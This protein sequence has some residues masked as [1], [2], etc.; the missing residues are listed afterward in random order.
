M[1]SVGLEKYILYMYP[2]SITINILLNYY[3]FNSMGMIGLAYSTLVVQF[4]ILL[5]LM[6]VG[7]YKLKNQGLVT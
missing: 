7:S 1:Q 2:V 6:I 4:F 5:Y 3:L